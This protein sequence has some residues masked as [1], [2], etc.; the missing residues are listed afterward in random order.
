LEQFWVEET[1]REFQIFTNQVNFIWL[2]D[3]SFDEMLNR[4]AALPAPSAILY[5]LLAVDAD[6]VPHEE[7]RALENLRAVANAPIFGL[8]DGVL[9]HGIVGG[10]LLSNRDLGRRAAEVAIRV[11]R[12]E[13]PANIKTPPLG[14]ATPVYDWRELQR[15]GISETRLPPGSAVEF[16]GPTVWERFYWQII[17]GCFVLL[18]QASI[19]SWLLIERHRRQRAETE[20]RSRM[21]EI[22]H[23]DRTTV[24]GALSAS[25]AHELNQ[26]LGAILSNAEAAEMLLEENP[27]DLGQVKEIL[28][29]IRQADQHAADIIAHF[30][31]LLKRG[32]DIDLQEFDLNE[33]IAGALRILSPEARR[34]GIALNP[35]GVHFALPV[36]ADQIHVQQVLLN[37]ATNGMDAMNEAASGRRE[38]GIETAL[39][40][41]AQVEVSVSDTGT[42]IPNDRLKDIFKTFYTTKQQ[43]TG[44]GLSIARTI[45]ETY[46]GKIWAENRARGGAVFRFTLPLVKPHP[47]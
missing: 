21:L 46:G 3:L 13:T 18:L 39:N 4:V 12:G 26:P 28:G 19:I 40:G 7:N 43:G 27:P 44:L 17:S 31:K 41:E 20:S 15:W 32:I 2:N 22:I 10:P 34:R 6:G 36:R 14:L 33:A 1:R 47:A 42:G 45:V 16:R 24:A 35:K 9:G 30:R 37:L 5:A 23:M 29:E 38:L 11:L 25:V 8:A